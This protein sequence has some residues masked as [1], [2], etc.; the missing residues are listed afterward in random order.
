[1]TSPTSSRWAPTDSSGSPSSANPRSPCAGGRPSR[2]QVRGPRSS[3]ARPHAA[4]SR[5]SRPTCRNGAGSAKRPGPSHRPPSSNRCLFH[6]CRRATGTGASGRALP[7]VATI[8]IVQ[9]EFDQGAAERY[10]VPV[11]YVSEVEAENMK[12]WQADAVIADL[13]VEESDG[14][15]IDAAHSPD[16]VRAVADL[17][18][19][20]RT[21]PG[22]HGQIVGLPSPSLRRF[23][24]C[25]RED[26]PSTPLSGEQSNTSVLLGDQAIMKFI[27]RFE[28]G[29]NP[30]V[31]ISRFLS[32]RARFCS[33][34]PGRRQHRIPRRRSGRG[35]RRRSPSW[36]STSPTR[37]TAGS[38]WWMRSHLGWRTR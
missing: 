35:S 36:R 9:L 21:L 38:T 20:R 19:R 24:G 1:M 15:L 25:L 28:E 37:A 23:N 34:P 27:R 22:R 12:K 5:G 6:P 26:C 4:S 3:T 32:E 31:E 17:L 11:A 7:P 30:G 33:R 29:I 8:L 14:V 13:R 16:F 18:A 10:V 2:R